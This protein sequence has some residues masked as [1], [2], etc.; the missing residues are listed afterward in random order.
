M[1][2]EIWPKSAVNILK[3]LQKLLFVYFTISVLLPEDM[4]WPRCIAHLE[5]STYCPLTWK[6]QAE[7]LENLPLKTVINFWYHWK[8]CHSQ[9]QIVHK[10][11]YEY[12]YLTVLCNFISI[13]WTTN[14]YVRLCEDLHHFAPVYQADCQHILQII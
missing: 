14:K 9:V 13:S 3:P 2:K 10:H 12:A 4:E 11:W 6:P 1:F 5:T 7:T 8:L